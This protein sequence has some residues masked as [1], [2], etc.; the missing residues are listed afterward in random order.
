MNE[1]EKAFEF[2]R[3]KAALVEAGRTAGLAFEVT[4]L[5]TE[6]ANREAICVS[7][8]PDPGPI[9][10]K[11]KYP[12]GT[13]VEI[14]N[15]ALDSTGHR[16]TVTQVAPGRRCSLYVRLDNEKAARVYSPSSVLR[17]PPPTIKPNDKVTILRP[18]SR[19]KQGTVTR[20]DLAK[21]YP[22]YVHCDATSTSVAYRFAELRLA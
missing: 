8:D 7:T 10:V 5:L 3:A 19:I 15:P 9:G 1:A 16:G 18:G 22:V 11:A 20:I 14:T 4:A 17:L 13:R 6:R 21:V 12:I 2:D